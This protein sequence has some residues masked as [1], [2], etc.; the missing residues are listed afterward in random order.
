[1]K[2][3]ETTILLPPQIA[4][5]IIIWILRLLEF[6]EVQGE[7]EGDGDSEGKG[8]FEANMKVKVVECTATVQL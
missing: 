2:V 8:E 5:Y 3:Q 4:K 1:M 7:G 6:S